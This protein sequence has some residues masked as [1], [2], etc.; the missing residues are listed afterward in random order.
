MSS[1]KQI[2]FT[3][4]CG[5][6]IMGKQDFSKAIGISMYKLSLIIKHN[7]TFFEEK[8]KTY[9]FCKIFKVLTRRQYI[10]N[11][12]GRPTRGRPITTMIPSKNC[13]YDKYNFVGDHVVRYNHAG[14]LLMTYHKDRFEMYLK[15]FF[16][17][18]DKRY[19]K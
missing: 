2:E 13:N 12:N 14:T 3:F 6:K 7:K 15:K 1:G 5:K 18:Y 17:F 8:G 4:P 16:M 9:K 11:P 10:P 19:H